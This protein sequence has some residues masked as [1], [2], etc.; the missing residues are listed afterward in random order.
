MKQEQE[1]QEFLELTTEAMDLITKAQRP[2]ETPGQTLERI[3]KW[4]Q[5]QQLNFSGTS[6]WPD[7]LD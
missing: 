6:T 2:G 7:S 5:S 1:N 3:F 4:N